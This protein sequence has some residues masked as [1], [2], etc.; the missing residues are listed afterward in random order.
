MVTEAV[1]T[2]GK[3]ILSIR[4]EQKGDLATRDG[5]WQLSMI[6]L[7]EM[8]TSCGLLNILALRFRHMEDMFHFQY[9]LMLL[10]NRNSID[11]CHY[12]YI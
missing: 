8:R 9:D 12:L 11:N 1:R 3:R 5:L 2:E 6:S 7:S 4:S 10:I